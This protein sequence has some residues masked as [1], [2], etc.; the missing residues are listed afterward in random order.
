MKKNTLVF[1]L[2]LTGTSTAGLAATRTVTL[3]VPGMTCP[4]CPI[5]VKR[6]LEKVNGVDTITSD[7]SKKTV[8]ITYDDAKTQPTALTRATA[9][10]GYPSTVQH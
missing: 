4:I 1:A 10:A 5:T 3:D 8:T 2:M 7:I 9:D 6:S